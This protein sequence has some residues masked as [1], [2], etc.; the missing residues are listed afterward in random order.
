M[1]DEP[2]TLEYFSVSVKP[3]IKFQVIP[4][5]SEIARRAGI[6]ARVTVQLVVHKNR[7]PTN[8]TILKGHP[9]LNE[10]ALEAAKKY[11][12][13]PGMQGDKPVS[14]KWNI[15]FNFRLRN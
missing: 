8:I 4:I 13:N 14:V 1:D 11:R 5:Y 15:P 12:F 10:A 9:M 7:L 6:E 2:E 3:T